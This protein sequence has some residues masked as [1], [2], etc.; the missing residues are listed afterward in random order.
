M[1]Q[2]VT[3]IGTHLLDVLQTGKS[4]INWLISLNTG[5]SFWTIPN[6]GSLPRSKPLAVPIWQLQES[7]QMST[8]MALPAPTRYLT[9]SMAGEGM[10]LRPLRPARGKRA[11]DVQYCCTRALQQ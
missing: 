1:W 10:G 3:G 5:L 9:T 6:S 7:P 4:V 11:A 8:P 2:S